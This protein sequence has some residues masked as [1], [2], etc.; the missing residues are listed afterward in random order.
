M[1][2]L[3]LPTDQS[4]FLALLVD[5][6]LLQAW[7]GPG[8]VRALIFCNHD[9]TFVLHNFFL[10]VSSCLLYKYLSVEGFP[11]VPGV[12]AVCRLDNRLPRMCP[13]EQLTPSHP[14]MATCS[15]SD[16]SATS[17]WT[18]QR[19]QPPV[20]SVWGFPYTWEGFHTHAAVCLCA[21]FEAPKPRVSRVKVCKDWMRW[22]AL[23]PELQR[24]VVCTMGILH[25]V[26]QSSLCAAG[27]SAAVPARGPAW[28]VR[29]AGGICQHQRPAD[30]G[31]RRELA[32]LGHAAGHIHLLPLCVQVWA[33]QGTKGTVLCHGRDSLPSS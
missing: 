12:D 17:V 31:H 13:T 33:P 9:V 6:S 8:Y 16:V 1:P 26:P 32:A 21:L 11:A 28:E 3:L 5:Q 19:S 27:G 15:G 24:R 14:R 30:R 7:L 20:P 22:V 10:Y 29:A 4:C 18:L 25:T 23:S 2:I